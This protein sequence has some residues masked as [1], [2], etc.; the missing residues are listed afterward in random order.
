MASSQGH[1]H[2]I[3]NSLTQR[4]GGGFDAGGV[5]PFRVARGLRT[6]LSQLFDV[7]HFEAIAAEKQLQVQ[8]EAGVSKGQN[9]A[10]ATNP[11]RIV[12]VVGHD[13]LKEVVGNRCQGHRG[14]GVT[15]A[16]LLDRVHGQDASRGYGS[17]I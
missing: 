14:A 13:V 7:V 8:G 5:L 15:V 16:G 4:S 12:G 17:S 9:E 11:V 2:A 6:P 10:I 3:T 1:T